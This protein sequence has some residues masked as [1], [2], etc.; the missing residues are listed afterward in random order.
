MILVSVFL[1]HFSG[2]MTVLSYAEQV[3]VETASFL[4]YWWIWLK[5]SSFSFY[6]RWTIV[7]F[8]SRNLLLCY[9][10]PERKQTFKRLDYIF[11]LLVY[12]IAYCLDLGF[13]PT[14][15]T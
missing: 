13:V 1:Q 12:F 10:K 3:F 7:T 11:A 2:V 9:I 4:D 6:I 8:Y 15:V 5:P 14:V